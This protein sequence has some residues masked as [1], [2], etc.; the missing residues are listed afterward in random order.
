MTELQLPRTNALGSFLPGTF[1]SIAEE[2]ER[3]IRAAGKPSAHKVD[4][5]ACA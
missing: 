1:H 3:E 5:Q 4:S 2:R